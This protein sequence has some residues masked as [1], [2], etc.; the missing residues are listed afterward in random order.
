MR[1]RLKPYTYVGVAPRLIMLWTVILMENIK[2]VL[3]EIDGVPDVKEFY[4]FI[5]AVDN[6]LKQGQLPSSV[7]DECPGRQY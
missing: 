7:S 5:V 2:K 6:R 1:F 3:D 4:E